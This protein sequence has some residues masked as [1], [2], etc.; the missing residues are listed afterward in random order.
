MIT[1]CWKSHGGSKTDRLRK[2]DFARLLGTGCLITLCVIFLGVVRPPLFEH[3]EN[4]TFDVLFSQTSLRTPSQVPI[5]ISI[6]DKALS[7]LGQWPWPRNVLAKVIS[8]LREAGVDIVALD[9]VLSS[10]DQTSP[11]VVLESLTKSPDLA[12]ILAGKPLAEFDFD[13]VLSQTLKNLPTVLGYKLLF[14]ETSIQQPCI[15]RPIQSNE[16]L[17]SIFD[18]HEALSVVCTLPSLVR[19][20]ASS[21]FINASYDQDGVIRRVPLVVHHAAGLLPGLTLAVASLAEEKNIF[22]GQNDDGGFVQ[23]GINRIQTDPQGNMLLRF[24]GPSGTFRTISV[25]DILDKPLPNLTGNIAIV[26]PTAAGLGDIHITPLDRTFPGIE[27]HATALDNIL[28]SDFLTHPTWASGAET[29]MVIAF[30]ILSSILIIVSGPLVCV[31][32]LTACSFGLWNASLWI[33]NNPGYWISPLQAISVIILNLSVLSLIKYGIEEHKLRIRSQ[34]LLQAQDAT[35]LGLTSLAET[36][37]PETGGHIKR[38][39]EY[40]RVL[41]ESLAQTS[42]YRILLDHDTIELLYKCAPLHDI[43]KVGI[44]DSILL[45][46]DRLTNDEYIEMQRHTI[47]GADTLAEAASQS[48][49]GT[50]KSFLVLA[51]EIALSHHEKWDGSGYPYGLAGPEIPL[52]GRLMALADVYDALVNKRVYKEAMS[53]EKAT[54]IIINGRGKHFDPDIVD[55]FLQSKQKFQEILSKYS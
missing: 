18:L 29:A 36:R 55:A 39:Q 8:R 49:Q 27:I 54:E 11:K 25:A 41:A 38:T 50:E 47:L 30:G 7:R 48:K 35:I 53:H 51:K 5:L 46:P 16:A 9:L 28:Q 32:S 4:K 33:L 37:D 1:A 45:K 21:G 31:L 13:H 15:L 2:R 24:R 19:A 40:V 43:G 52:G 20:S 12:K 26:G 44:A 6:D 10:R 34:E 22:L 14:T 3:I 23:L 42:K 17:P